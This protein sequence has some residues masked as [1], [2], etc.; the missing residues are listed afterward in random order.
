MKHHRKKDGNVF[1]LWGPKG[2]HGPAGEWK[3]GAGGEDF[4]LSAE[5][6]PPTAARAEWRLIPAWFALGFHNSVSDL[7]S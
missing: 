4:P 3:L 5:R 2:G 7:R 6:S 1:A